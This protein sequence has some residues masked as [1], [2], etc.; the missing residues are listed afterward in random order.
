MR[1]GYC[2]ARDLPS[3]RLRVCRRTKLNEY[4]EGYAVLICF[5]RPEPRRGILPIFCARSWEVAICC[6]EP[7]RLPRRL[8]WHTWEGHGLKTSIFG[9]V[10]GCRAPG[11]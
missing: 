2:V 3:S 4:C 11:I 1:I 8:L 5:Q 6:S 9:R 7:D 10:E